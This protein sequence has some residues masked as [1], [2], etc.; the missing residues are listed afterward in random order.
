MLYAE[1][2]AL[3]NNS[4]NNREI[5]ITSSSDNSTFVAIKYGAPAKR[6]EYQYRTTGYSI[7]AALFKDL[8]DST[9][10]LKIAVTWKLNEFKLF[11]NGLQVGSTDTSGNVSPAGTF[12]VLRFQNFEGKVKQVLVFNTALSDADLATL[13]TI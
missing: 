5:F 2:A 8:V 4:T 1:I 9:S 6:I 3:D 10:F 13:T 12:D 11:I 7:Q